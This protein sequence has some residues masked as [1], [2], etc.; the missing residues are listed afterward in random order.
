MAYPGY[1]GHGYAIPPPPAPPV[2]VA[3]NMADFVYEIAVPPSPES[4]NRGEQEEEEQK[5]RILC[6]SSSTKEH[7]RAASV[8]VGDS[9]DRRDRSR[10]RSTYYHG[11]GGG[12]YE[13]E[14]RDSRDKVYYGRNEYYAESTYSGSSQGSRENSREPYS[15]HHRTSSAHSDMGDRYYDTPYPPVPPGAGA[16]PPVPAPPP[17]PGQPGNSMALAP[18]HPPQH[19]PGPPFMAPGP[20][21]PWQPQ[22]VISPEQEELNKKIAELQLELKKS[23]E[24]SEKIEK[25]KAE[26]EAQRKKEAELKEAVK[27]EIDARAAAEQKAKEAAA[28]EQARIQEQAR[29]LLEAQEAAKKAA[30]EKDKEEKAKVEKLVEERIAAENQKNQAVMLDL[31]KPTHTKFSK[32]HLCKEALDERKISYTEHEDSF[33]VHRWVDRDEQNQLWARTKQIRAYQLEYQKRFKE[34]ADKAPVIDTPNGPVKIVRV[35]NNPPVT[36]PVVLVTKKAPVVDD[37]KFRHIFGMR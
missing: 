29:K 14:Y 32:T 26:V 18:L 10:P 34:E 5:V 33:L 21:V 35:G 4:P 12:R 31:R 2:N 24:E 28:A 1:P 27:R 15:R 22:V 23:K 8:H 9:R 3:P 7:R 20:M 11:G 30:E 25:T 13:D 36:V 16:W 17:M 6:R 37:V 19:H